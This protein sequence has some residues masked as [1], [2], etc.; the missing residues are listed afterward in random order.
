[1][2][3]LVIGAGG[4]EHALVWK[5]R[6]SPRVSAV[7]CAPGNAGIARLATCVPIAAD[8]VP[9]LRDWALNNQIDLTIPGP[10]AALVAG[11][12]DAFRQAGLAVWGPTQAAAQLE[13]SKSYAKHFMTEHGIPTAAFQTFDTAAGAHAYVRAATR[14][15]VVKADGLAAGKG[16]IVCSSPEEAHAAV[17]LIMVERSFGDAG[18]RVVIEERL[19]GPEV[20]VLAFCDGQ[21][22]VP[23]LPARDHK[24]LCDGDRGPNTGGMGAVAPA[25]AQVDYD[26]ITRTILQ[27]TLDGMARR[28]AP[29]TGILYA[30]LML[31]EH[32]PYVI[33]YNC[34]FGDPEAQ[35]LLP[36]LESDL[37]DVAEACLAGALTPDMLRWRSH[38]CVCVVLAAHGYPDRPRR[39]DPISGCDPAADA[40]LAAAGVTVFHAG[41][42]LHDGQLVTAGGRV[43]GV[44]AVAPTLDA[45]RQHA[46]AAADQIT[47]D[48]STLR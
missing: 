11:V 22:A 21:Q 30:G 36:L 43:L 10:E 41:T 23:L 31:T 4:R 26:R 42:A 29:Y 28:G 48:G 8:D 46:Y 20:S 15:L 27:P 44:T 37:L 3:V 24:R 13:G 45:A 16:V 40:R 1:M 17:D 35:A 18:K 34:R 9:A 19:V 12:V 14:P 25:Y 39:G 33:E 38:T 5:V 7:Y 32:G 47:F 2:R 6:Q